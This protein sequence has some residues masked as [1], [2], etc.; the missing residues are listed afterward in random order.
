MAKNGT[1]RRISNR[2]NALYSDALKLGGGIMYRRN[3][4]KLL[5]LHPHGPYKSEKEYSERWRKLCKNPDLSTYRLYAQYIGEDTRIAPEDIVS[6]IIQP[7]LNPVE[8]RGYYQDKNMF[9]KIIPKSMLPVTLLRGIRGNLFDADY[10]VINSLEDV[11]DNINSK[12]DCVFLKPAV[13]TSSGEGVIG[14]SR[15]HDGKLHSMSDGKVLDKFTIENY[16]NSSPEFILQRGLVQH[17]YINQFNPSSINTIRIAT[18]R[19]VRDGKPHFLNATIRIGKSGSFVDNGHAGGLF[20]GV[21]ANGRLGKYACD[22]YGNKYDSFNG[23][24]FKNGDY[25]IPDF[26]EIKRFSETV[27]AHVLHAR[28]I[29]HDICLQA[30]GKPKLVE[31]NIRAFSVWL[32]QFTSGP[33]LGEYT[34]EIIDYCAQH[35]NEVKKVFVEPF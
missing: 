4:A 26:E 35:K 1:F 29:A 13:D 10:Q 31:F 30:N 8:Y 33:A 25:V 3:Y 18:Y 20:V 6:G 5:K 22:Q 28:L 11:I 34:D 32:F 27:A 2:I 7:L 15:T 23:I 24:N 16:M 19:S 9:E 17:P 14:F 12:E 21:D